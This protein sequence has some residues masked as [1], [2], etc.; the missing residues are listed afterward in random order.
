VSYVILT[1]AY[2]EEKNIGLTIE[3]VLAQSIKPDLWIIIDDGSQDNTGNIIKEYAADNQWIIYIYNEKDKECSYYASN[4]YAIYK[5]IEHLKNNNIKYDYLAILD[6]DIELPQLYYEKI[7]QLFNTIDYLGIASGHCLDRVGNELVEGI[8]DWRSAPKNI[9]VFKRECYE[10]IGGFL[11]LKFA[12]EDTHA[13]Y[14]ARMKGWNVWA[15]TDLMV[16]HNKPLGTAL[17]SN[18]FKIRFN[19]GV[20][21]YYL[22]THPLFMILKSIKRS[23]REA[24]YLIGGFVRLIGFVFAPL[25]GGKRQISNELIKFIRAEQLGRIFKLSDKSKNKMKEAVH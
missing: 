16:V 17:T 10:E 20:A 12:G 19:Q 14:M 25:V 2:N 23:L 18:I 5:G 8:Y 13:C 1:P 11:P 6:A 3:S 15:T 22:A 24:P 9:M 21:E 4:V 7:F